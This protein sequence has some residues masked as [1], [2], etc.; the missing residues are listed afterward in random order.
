MFL[1]ELLKQYTGMSLSDMQNLPPQVGL[2]LGFLLLSAISL[3]CVFNIIFY[4]LVIIT[5][6]TDYIK[7]ILSANSRTAFYL[8]RL[9]NFYKKSSITFIALEFCFIIYI[10]GFIIH[11]CYLIVSAYFFHK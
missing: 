6:D 4:L 3:F 9:L 10:H 5:I 8:K 11:T 2:L 7:N 1:L